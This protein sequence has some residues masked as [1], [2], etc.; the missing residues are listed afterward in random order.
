ML[1][2]LVRVPDAQIGYLAGDWFTMGQLLSLPML[3]AG[4]VLLLRA[5]LQ[6][7][8]SGNFAAAA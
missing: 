5:K 7:R 6:P 3:L 2:E 8:A 4:V 1:I